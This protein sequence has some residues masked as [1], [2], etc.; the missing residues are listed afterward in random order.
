MVHHNRPINKR[1]PPYTF[2]KKAKKIA[3]LEKSIVLLHLCDCDFNATERAV[4]KADRPPTDEPFAVIWV[5]LEQ[6]VN[7]PKRGRF[8]LRDFSIGLIIESDSS[9][10][11]SNKAENAKF[12]RRN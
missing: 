8:N 1:A 4:N 2:A 11:A 7:R 12:I 10:F 9:R 3:N 5:G 6:I